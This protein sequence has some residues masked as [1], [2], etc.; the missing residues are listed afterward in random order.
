MHNITLQCI[1]GGHIPQ[2]ILGQSKFDSPS[3]HLINITN[4]MELPLNTTLP[5]IEI[6]MLNH[7]SIGDPLI[8]G[9]Q[10]D[11]TNPKERFM[12]V[13]LWFST[14][15]ILIRSVPLNQID[16]VFRSKLV[17]WKLLAITS[18]DDNTEHH[19]CCGQDSK[20]FYYMEN[21]HNGNI[22]MIGNECLVH[23]SLE[24]RTAVKE[25]Y[26]KCRHCNTK[27]LKTD[28]QSL[29]RKKMCPRCYHNALPDREQTHR[30]CE[31]CGKLSVTLSALEYHNLCRQCYLE[32]RQQMGYR[33][34]NNCHQMRISLIEPNWKTL[35]PSC[36]GQTN[37]GRRRWRRGH[38]RF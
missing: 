34:C 19:C 6:D 37:Q 15:K 29:G 16:Q 1:T 33:E 27:C 8:Q 30:P 25:L 20:E 9:F 22:L 26:Y 2:A 14:D 7:E 4:R 5:N 3:H 31:N 21:R 32:G 17:E 18:D 35:C 38:R 28:V 23:F 10:R 13:V 12:A 11:I 24:E 36:Y